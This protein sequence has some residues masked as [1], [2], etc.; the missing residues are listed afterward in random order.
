MSLKFDLLNQ[1]TVAISKAS[2]ELVVLQRMVLVE[3]TRQTAILNTQLQIA[4]IN[5]LEKNRDVIIYNNVSKT[6]NSK[7]IKNLNFSLLNH[8]LQKYCRELRILDGFYGY[9]HSTLMKYHK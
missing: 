3:G 9:V 5:E 8:H 6:K 4:K 2:A 7:R 1:T